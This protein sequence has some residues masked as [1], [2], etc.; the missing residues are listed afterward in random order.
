MPST[1]GLEVL[2]RLKERGDRSEVVISGHGTIA[3]AVEATTRER[4]IS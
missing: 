4:L 1:D 3:T 2:Q